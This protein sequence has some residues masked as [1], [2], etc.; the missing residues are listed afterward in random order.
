M[1]TSRAL[2]FS[3]PALALLTACDQ[4]M[5][6]TDAS[7]VLAIDAVTACATAGTIAQGEHCACASDCAGDNVTCLTE[8][9]SMFPQG[10]CSSPCG[11]GTE[12]PAGTT[13]RDEVC[14]RSC[15]EASDCGP[16]SLCI[17]G[18]CAP[19][20]DEDSDC[21]SG[22]CNGYIGHCLSAGAPIEGLGIDAPCTAGSECRSGVCTG[23]HCTSPCSVSAG[24]CPDGAVCALV[25]G[26]LGLCLLP[27]SAD[28]PCESPDRRCAAINVDT[29]PACLPTSSAG[30]RGRLVSPSAGFGCGCDGDCDDGSRCVDEARAGFPQ[31][32][33]AVACTDDA[34]C[35]T[36][37][38]CLG[39]VCLHRC[40]TDDVC[41]I[42]RLCVAD[43]CYPYCV[44]DAECQSGFCDR[45]AG[46][47]GTSP[48]AGRGAGATCAADTDCASSICDTS[49]HADGA[50]LVL[51]STTRGACPDEAVCVP[52]GPG[53]TQGTCS[54]PCG[55]ASDCP[56]ATARCVP[57]SPGVASHC[58]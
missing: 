8:E 5:A 42:G 45:E 31:G 47:C 51:C 12:C 24:L 41:G 4:P 46:R 35:P 32:L 54:L 43:A 33:C 21:R 15:S 48:R 58:E 56:Q 39:G 6:A 9:V 40:V 16:E 55:T 30:C 19:H 11:G 44:D 53:A 1:R 7:R 57:S 13:C 28:R 2:R 18:I 29:P 25:S 10:M 22:H 37:H 14:Y 3:L 49:L 52:D 23:G 27:C 50:C 26:D 20:C 38:A 36:S 34:E 17:T